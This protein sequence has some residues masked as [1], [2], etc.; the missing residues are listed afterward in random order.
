MYYLPIDLYRYWIGR[1]DQSVQESVTKKRYSHQI[2]VTEKSFVA[3]DIGSINEPKLKRYLKHEMFLMFGISIMFSRLNKSD[4]TDAAVRKMWDT[5]REHDRR[6]TNHY[7]YRSPL[8]L[9]CI[10]G[11]FGR[12]LVEFFYRIANKIVR[13]N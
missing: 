5:C 10:G 9:I 6:W 11:K 7:R 8:A 4:E 13:F 1:P 12:A 2:S 3:C